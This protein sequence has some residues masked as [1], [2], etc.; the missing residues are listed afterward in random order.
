MSY[1]WQQL[2]QPLLMEGVA[3]HFLN[4]LHVGRHIMPYSQMTMIHQA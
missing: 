3:F 2:F 1:I 4:F